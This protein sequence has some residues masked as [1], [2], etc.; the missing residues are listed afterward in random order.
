MG[1]WYEFIT[2]YYKLMHLF[3]HFITDDRYRLQILQLLQGEVYDREKAGVLDEMRKVIK[4]VEET[5]GHIWKPYLS[6]I[7]IA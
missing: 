3:S 4:T 7:P 1:V 2:L 5:E 6:D